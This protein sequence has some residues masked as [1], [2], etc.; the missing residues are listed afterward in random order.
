[1]EH[2]VSNANEHRDNPEHQQE[3]P[4]GLNEP[5]HDRKC[6]PE[7]RLEEAIEGAGT[8]PRACKRGAGS[9]IECRHSR[10]KLADKRFIKVQARACSSS[11]TLLTATSKKRRL[12]E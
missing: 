12:S 10:K 1:M 2:R 11:S 4:D 8:Y 3:R 5:D 7:H 9:C 6:L